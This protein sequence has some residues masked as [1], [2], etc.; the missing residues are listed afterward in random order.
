LR[1]VDAAA[2][3][4][5]MRRA[6]LHGALDMGMAP[7]LLPGRVSLSDGASWFAAKWGSGPSGLGMDTAQMLSAAAVGTLKAL[8]LVG[9]DPLSD[10]PDR[11][12]AAK[13][14]A[15]VEYLVS[16]DTH[17]NDSN[18]GAHVL[19]PAAGY[20]EK[21]GTTTN[22]EGRVSLLAAKV[23]APGVARADW[24]IAWELGM[25]LGTDLGFATLDEVTAEIAAVAP[26]HLGLTPAVLRAAGNADGVLLPLPVASSESSASADGVVEAAVAQAADA[27]PVDTPGEIVAEGP[28]VPASVQYR[29]TSSAAVAPAPDS[30]SIR[31]HSGRVLYDNGTLL[32]AAPSLGKLAPAPGVHLHPNEIERQGL[33][34][35]Q[36][37]KVLSQ[38]GSVTLTIIADDRVP[39]GVAS[40]PFNQA[41]PGAADLIDSASLGAEG[42]TRVRLESVKGA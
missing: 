16:I 32:Q 34:P 36:A 38:T 7:G 2:F 28:V 35:G 20:A 31:L 39:R 15:N 4:P 19:L 18:A 25:A 1:S 27:D 5:A 30:Y 23:S 3:L 13:A 24:M 33:V 41:G 6:N 14:L 37:V 21:S 17:T 40:I 11:A 26:S 22:M 29:F 9:A 42:V 12:L 8:V 10:F